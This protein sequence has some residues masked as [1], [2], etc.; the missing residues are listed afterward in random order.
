ML[1]GW[2]LAIGTA[3]AAVGRADDRRT[4]AGASVRRS[5]RQNAGKRK[6]KRKRIGDRDR[7]PRPL[8]QLSAPDLQHVRA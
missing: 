6:L 5:A 8:P 2:R 4:V 7:D 3:G 1:S